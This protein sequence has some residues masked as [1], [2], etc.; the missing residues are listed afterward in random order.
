MKKVVMQQLQTRGG[1]PK[2]AASKDLMSKL[3]LQVRCMLATGPS[4]ACILRKRNQTADDML[5]ADICSVLECSFRKLVTLTP[6]HG[7]GFSSFAEVSTRV[8]LGR[9]SLCMTCGRVVGTS[10][11][12]EEDSASCCRESFRSTAACLIVTHN[13]RFRSIVCN[14]GCRSNISFKPV[15]RSLP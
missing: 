8:F 15:W 14:L 2:N 11:P 9:P 12:H 1:D 5:R 10:F 13:N 6:A 7:N 3:I 4:S